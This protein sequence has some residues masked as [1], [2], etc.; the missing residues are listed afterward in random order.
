MISETFVKINNFPI[1]SV[2][3]ENFD[4]TLTDYD[5]KNIPIEEWKTILF[6]I[7]F[8]MAVAQKHLNFIHNDLHS[9]N[10]MFKKI[11]KEFKYYNYN[12]TYFKV[13]TYNKETK[14]IDFARGIIKIGPTLYFSDVFKKG[15]DAYGQYKYLNKKL[16]YKHKY[17]NYSFDLAR[18]SITLLKYLD[19]TNKNEIEKYLKE[20]IILKNNKYINMEEDDFSVYVDLC[21]NSH[22]AIPKNQ[23]LKP[24]FKEFIINKDEIPDNENIY[25]L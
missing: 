24:F 12:N 17:L 15:G 22:N 20:L 8:G 11:N 21:E 6:E 3:M 7:C 10:I 25:I 2:I 13:P 14:I 23:L 1:Q 18:L 4:M 16:F 19:F 9:D 5:K